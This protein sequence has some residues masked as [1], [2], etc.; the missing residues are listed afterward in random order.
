MPITLYPAT[1]MSFASMVALIV[2]QTPEKIGAPREINITSDSAQGWLPSEE[3]EKRVRDT[4]SRYFAA[5]DGGNYRAAYDMMSDANKAML[6]YEQFHRQSAQFKTQAGPLVRRDV[7]KI[8]WT[9]DSANAPS[10]GV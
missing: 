7:L 5:V 8:T 10:P 4:V 3:L 2:A 1:L 6:P 9:K